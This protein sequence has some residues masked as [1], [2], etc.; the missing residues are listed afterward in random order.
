MSISPT[1]APRRYPGR[2][3][4]ALGLGLAAL[5]FIGY[6]VQVSAHRLS[7]P[8]Y[9]PC[10]ATLGV[11]F[12]AV[13]LWQ[14]RSLWRV[15]GLLL[16]VVLAGFEWL[17]LL[18]LPLPPYTGKIAAGQPFPPFE[19]VRAD[20]TPFTQKNLEGDQNNVLVFFR[21]RW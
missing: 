14:A 11:V 15:L 8:W 13:S 19:V 9:L 1:V 2:L 21:G 6:V 16:V 17:F 20:D 3:F 12:I 4:L 10:S 7:T 18:G 5:G